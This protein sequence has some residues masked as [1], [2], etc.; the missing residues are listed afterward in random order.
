VFSPISPIRITTIKSSGTSL[1]HDYTLFIVSSWQDQ[2]P[3]F[4]YR[5]RK[6]QKSSFNKSRKGRCPVPAEANCLMSGALQTDDATSPKSSTLT[7]ASRD[8]KTTTQSS[9][10]GPRWTPS[11]R[12]TR[13]ES[14]MSQQRRHNSFAPNL[15]A[16]FALKLSFAGRGYCSRC[17]SRGSAN[18]RKEMTLL[19]AGASIQGSAERCREMTLL[20]VSFYLKY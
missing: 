16:K 17:L 1:H 15:V 3:K 19:R 11:A 12:Q 9:G 8:A 18:I 7:K 20:S 14:R 10:P 13:R 2:S 6:G 5:N 4:G